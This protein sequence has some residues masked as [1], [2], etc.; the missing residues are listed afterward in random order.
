[1]SRFESDL[2]TEL[3]SHLE[4]RIRRNVAAGMPPEEARRAALRQFGPI[5]RVKEQCRETR[6]VIWLEQV[7]RES[8]LAV[9]TLWKS[10]GFSSAVILTLALG[11]GA[12]AAVFT[13]ANSLLFK[14]LPW[15]QSHRVVSIWETKLADPKS[16]T[17]MA[18][19]QFLDLHTNLKSFKA[20]AGWSPNGVNMAPKDGQP[21]RF[22]GASV[23]ERF[24]DVVGVP[25]AL[26]PGFNVDH[27]KEGN[28]GVALIAH[29]IWRDQFALDP[30][31]VGRSVRINGRERTIVGVMPPG[32]QT[33]AKA[34]F[35]MPRLF[36]EHEHFDRNYKA[37]PILGR[38]ADNVTLEQ[39]RAE[40]ATAFAAIAREH[41]DFLK[42]WGTRINPALED[43]AKPARPSLYVLI[44]AVV[45]VLV[46]ACVNVANLTLARGVRRL[47]ELSLRAALGASRGKLM[48]QLLI[49]NL[50]LAAGG[51]A[52]GLFIAKGLLGFLLKIAPQTLPRIDQV[53]IDW[54]T[55]A[56]AFA[57][58][59]VSAVIFGIAPAWR[60][61]QRDPARELKDCGQRSASGVGW[62]R[63]LLAA[64]QV[65]A[66]VIVL[67]A[68]AL[69]LQSFER[70]LRQ[71]LGFKA[72][73]LW[74]ARLELPAA[75][76]RDE[77][78]RELFADEVIRELRSTPGIQKAAAT[79]YL[80]LMGWPHIIMRL[81][82][83]PGI[84]VNEAPHVGYQGVSDN[85]LSTMGMRV[86][87]GRDLDSRDTP[88]ALRVCLVN[89]AFVR[90]YYPDGDAL[91]K[92]IEIGFADPPLW[93][94]IVGIFNDARNQA[95]D[96]EPEEQVIV[97]MAQ[98][99]DFF[100]GSPAISIV[101]ATDARVNVPDAMRRAVWKIDRDQPLHL[102]RPMMDVLVDHR[103]NRRFTVTVLSLFAGAAAMLAAIG[104]FGVMSGDVAARTREFGVRMALGAEPKSVIQLA[105]KS[106]LGTLLMGLVAGSFGAWTATRLITSMLY[107]TK[108]YD[109]LAWLGVILSL[110]TLG[111]L[112]SYF[113][114]RR[115][116]RVDP[117]IALRAE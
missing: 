22:P 27:F 100:R 55:V 112:A 114:A 63:K 116:G 66:S 74:T 54:W 106:G 24:F 69:L 58:C 92:R 115:A 60:L 111:L 50:L 53:R 78:R 17:P 13:V 15:P 10:P 109:P 21:G 7:A 82:S 57:A 91:G 110:M 64:F 42:G 87:R 52:L 56:F 29:G 47:G 32:F 93:I 48:R 44:A 26:G 41:A 19:A 33:P 39:A 31:I 12:T 86:L 107:Q 89:E 37:L 103:A 77:N 79:T 43:S 80:P 4:E 18:P 49:E 81:E 70:L 61:S 16:Q 11:I 97:P 20:I 25:P 90:Q 6:R 104:L 83:N 101:A 96:A 85:Y 59:L 5:D 14:P 62:F 98:Q 117:M 94:E 36:N 73:N 84:A 9:R 113:P 71:D 95:L 3:H 30:N 68:T 51:G 8:R 99:P 2:D 108:P 23:T 67:L 38:L 40:L 1:M 105:L 34:Q 102:L 28:D 65:A 45:A 46:M 75:K 35:W 88:E 76:Y 72:D